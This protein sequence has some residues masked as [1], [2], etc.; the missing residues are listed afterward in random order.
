MAVALKGNSPKAGFEAILQKKNG[1]KINSRT[2]VSPLIDEKGEQ[3][4]W[5]SSIV[6]HNGAYQSTTRISIGSRTVHHS[7]GKS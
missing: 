6:D 1:V 2:F 3:S 7:I 5:I 4:G